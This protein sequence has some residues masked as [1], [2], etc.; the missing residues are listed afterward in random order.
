MSPTAAPEKAQAGSQRHQSML[1]I[2]VSHVGII[3]YVRLP[4]DDTERHTATT[5]TTTNTIA[6]YFEASFVVT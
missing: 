4:K 3:V 5:T 1:S 6:T 2:P